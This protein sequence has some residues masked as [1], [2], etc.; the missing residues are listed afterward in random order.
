MVIKPKIY[1]RYTK[2]KNN[3]NTTLKIIIKSQEER[4]KEE[5][6]IKRPTKIYKARKQQHGNYTYIGNYIKCREIK[7]PNQKT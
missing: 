5:G 3:P 2:K 1:N 4:T 7:C 6:K